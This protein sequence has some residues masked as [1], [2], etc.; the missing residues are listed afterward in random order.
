M[1][2]RASFDIDQA[3][4]DLAGR[5]ETL[6]D[7]RVR[8]TYDFDD[9][10]ESA[11]FEPTGYMIE[12]RQRMSPLAT[13]P[14]ESG[15]RV[16]RGSFTGRGSECYRLPVAFESPMSMTVE[17]SYGEVPPNG[18]PE[19]M[20]MLGICDDGRE[21]FASLQGHGTV[22]VTDRPSGYQVFEPAPIVELAVNLSYLLELRH[23]GERF[24]VYIDGDRIQEVDAGPRKAGAV[25]ML[26]HSDA[27][28][29]IHRLVIEGTP[30]EELTRA[31]W[32]GRRLLAL[33]F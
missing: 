23:S 26:V 21:S 12:R 19:S 7:G 16:A 17:V 13:D 9:A 5:V 29:T 25:W 22:E 3:L 6:R 31:E 15:L 32:V 10:V 2:S 1:R 30:S 14:E 28:V 18:T 11:D 27:L 20:L 24:A 8:V 4:A 33:G